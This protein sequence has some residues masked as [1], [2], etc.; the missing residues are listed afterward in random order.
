[1]PS[2]GET[3][4]AL[5]EAIIPSPPDDDTAGASD[6]AA[7]TFVTHY[8]E[9]VQP[10]LEE[11]LA[12]SLDGAAANYIAGEF[13]AGLFAS[14]TAEDRLHVIRALAGHDVK[15]LR[16]LADLAILLSFAAYYG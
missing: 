3:I 7:E 14:L 4:R 11:I 15:E 2:P 10:G 13:S 5:A 8:L 6:I 16:E 1:M 9:F 12:A